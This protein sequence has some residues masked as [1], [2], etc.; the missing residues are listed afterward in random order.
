MIP[1]RGDAQIRGH[2]KC[3]DTK[4]REY[5]NVRIIKLR[6]YPKCEDTKIR[7]HTKCDDA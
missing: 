7:G 6:G 4:I 2:P 1:K 5:L 3:E